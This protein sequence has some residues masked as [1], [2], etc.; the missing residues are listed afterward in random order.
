M[1]IIG[2]P[3]DEYVAKQINIRQK[4][5]STSPRSDETLLV[6][7]GSRPWLRAAS[8]VDLQKSYLSEL[9]ASNPAGNDLAKKTVLQNTVTDY[10]NINNPA[11]LSGFNAYEF[12]YDPTYGLKPPPGVES[13]TVTHINNGSIRVGTLK[14]KCFT[15]KQFDLIVALYLRIGYT[16]LVEWGHSVYF[17]NSEV[18]QSQVE[19]TEVLD[20]FLNGTKSFE[21]LLTAISSKRRQSSGNYNGFLG[22]VTNFT[23]T[24]VDGTYDIEIKLITQGALIESLVIAASINDTEAEASGNSSVVNSK[25][26]ITLFT[27]VL[28]NLI[29]K[30]KES[31]AIQGTT[32]TVLPDNEIPDVEI[33]RQKNVIIGVQ[34]GG[35]SEKDY[36]IKFGYLLYLLQK[37]CLVYDKRNKPVVNLYYSGGWEEVLIEQNP[38]SCSGDLDKVY[39]PLQTDFVSGEAYLDRNKLVHP[40]NVTAGFKSNTNPYIGKLYHLH[41]NI[42]FVN[43]LITKATTTRKGLL[44]FKLLNDIIGEIQTSMGNVNNLSVSYEEESNRL[45]IYDKSALTIDKSVPGKIYNGEKY[46]LILGGVKLD[47]YG[48]FTTKVELQSEVPNSLQSLAGIGATVNFSNKEDV[49]LFTLMNSGSED[50]ILGKLQ[51]RLPISPD[52]NSNIDLTKWF[53]YINECYGESRFTSDI[54][55]AF[56]ELN[57]NV[58][59]VLKQKLVDAGNKNPSKFIPF[60]LKVS[61]LGLSGFKLLEEITIADGGA[62]I[63]PF[64]LRKNFRFV[65]K[66][67]TETVTTTNWV[68]GLSTFVV[69]ADRKD[70]PTYNKFTIDRLVEAAV[71]EGPVNTKNL[72]Q[73]L[74]E[75]VRKLVYY[76]TYKLGFSTGA[77][78]G[79][80]GNIWRESKFDPKSINSTG[81][82]SSPAT[83]LCQW[84][85]TRR[86][87][88]QEQLKQKQVGNGNYRFPSELNLFDF[89]ATKKLSHLDFDLQLFYIEAELR[90]RKESPLSGVLSNMKAA[91]SVES[92][93]R[94]WMEQYE[95][96]PSAFDKRLAAANDYFRRLQDVDDLSPTG[97]KVL[98]FREQYS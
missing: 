2:L 96:T 66:E 67:I 85:F 14:L 61:M 76:L 4:K 71:S 92:A 3:I 8:S 20:A 55:P 25:L 56:T 44:L 89:A 93:T 84:R 32:I 49:S 87:S 58:Q 80:L 46:S 35:S 43:E 39:Y 59:V 94:I 81:P 30:T 68:T 36:Y 75:N 11:S 60:N 86:D 12:R 7:N 51:D 24:N 42:D 72:L 23:F 73:D 52:T 22:R 57:K 65:L 6:F 78:A 16:M 37:F 91:T 64:Y 15:P 63:I 27:K 21:E 33:G 26:D 48:A 19:S 9:Q 62:G 28:G 34:Q 5:L 38:F 10:T 45:Y 29:Q 18:Y 83:G 41:V 53:N 31:G 1:Q 88:Y 47:T 77:V 54:A 50:R 79:V 97:Q 70:T 90:G 98:S 13:F 95:Q 40:R 69:S 17:D 74:E 82:S